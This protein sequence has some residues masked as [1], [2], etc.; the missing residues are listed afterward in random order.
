MYGIVLFDIRLYICVLRRY[1]ILDGKLYVLIQLKAT[2]RIY[3][4]SLLP[5]ELFVFN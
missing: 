5:F 1:Y 3:L 4:H 2:E